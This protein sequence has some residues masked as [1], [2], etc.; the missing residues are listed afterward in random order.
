MAQL[1]YEEFRN[2]IKDNIKSYLAEEYADYKM[3]FQQFRNSRGEYEGLVIRSN[4]KVTATPTLNITKAYEDYTNGRDIEDI[5]RSLADIRMN[6]SV[7]A[8]FDI[9]K[10]L[11]WETVKGRIIPRLIN[12]RRNKEYLSNKLCKKLEDLSIIYSVIVSSDEHSMSAAAVTQELASAWNADLEI[13]HDQAMQ[14]LES[15]PYFFSDM[16][17]AMLRMFSN[18]K[19]LSIDDFNPDEINIPFFILSSENKVHGAVQVI[20]TPVM[21]KISEKLG[22]IY[23]IP[24]STEEVIIVPKKSVDQDAKGL[25]K[26]VKSVNAKEVAPEEVLSNNVYEYDLDTHSIK[27]AV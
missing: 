18:S 16:E 10:M 15:R 7:N 6:A 8:A 27:I 21:D 12:T 1:T 9:T 14:N 4:E 19:S 24:S 5:L 20:N 11:D 26:M 23:I 2:E 13:I 25:A 3:E 22:D 17:S